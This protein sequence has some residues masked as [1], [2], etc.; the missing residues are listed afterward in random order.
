MTAFVACGGGTFHATAVADASTLCASCVTSADCNGAVCAQVGGD[1]YCVLACPNGDECA[2]G[3]TCAS[4]TTV[5]G[6]Q[7]SACLSLTNICGTGQGAP[8]PTP[9]AGCAGIIAPTSDAGSCGQCGGGDGGDAGGHYC[10]ANGCRHGLYCD[11][12]TNTCEEEPS[13][14]G[15]SAFPLDA[16]PGVDGSVTASGGTVSRLYFAVVGDTRPPNEDETSAYPTAIIDAIFTDVTALDPMPS[17]VVSTGDYQ[18]ASTTGSQQAPQL[19]LYVAARSKYPGVQFPAMGNHECTGATASNCG[20]GNVDGIT[21][22]YTTFVSKLLAP[23]NQTSP[24]YVVNIDAADGSW[25]AKFVFIAANA[26]TTAQ[27]TWLDQALAVATT[28][29]F[30]VRHESAD[31][32][33][34]PGVT[35]SEAIIAQHPYTLEIVGHTHTYGH[36][37]AK[38]VLFGN[39][40]A[41]LSGSGN[42]GY[43]IFSQQSDGTISV[44]AIDYATGLADGTFHFAVKADGTAAP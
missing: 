29:T 17:F 12:A 5:S 28:Y 22:N 20:T 39:G 27:G 42:Y 15:G 24:Y 3:S 23:I 14:C 10:Q 43:G 13:A 1:S 35:P 26:W 44:D 2:S 25:T 37:A 11:T 38:E 34:T 19:D 21:T 41:P 31:T 30:V 33:T 40:G 7:Q 9:D 36:I 4:V 6:D 16:G 8:T 32:T 18:F